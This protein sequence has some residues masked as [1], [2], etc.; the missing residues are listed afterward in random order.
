MNK[1]N[2]LKLIDSFPNLYQYHPLFPGENRDFYFDCEDGWFQIIW[3]LSEKLENEFIRIKKEDGRDRKELPYVEH[4]KKRIGTLDFSVAKYND[5]IDM[6]T[7][8]AMQKSETICEIC[9]EP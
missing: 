8:K 4:V 5:K 7:L 2:S 6:Y 9:G 1:K 3:D